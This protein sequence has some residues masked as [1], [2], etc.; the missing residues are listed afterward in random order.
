M[1]IGVLEGL[2]QL[3]GATM[4]PVAGSTGGLRPI[5]FSDEEVVLR[6][7]AQQQ[8]AEPKGELLLADASPSFDQKGGREIAPSHGSDES[9][10]KGRV[11]V[12]REQMA[13]GHDAR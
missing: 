9:G 12:K 10:A 5:G 8:P 11:A 4:R 2:G 13:G 6:I 3:A 1:Q 7:L